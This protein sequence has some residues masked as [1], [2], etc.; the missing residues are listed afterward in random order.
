VRQL[1][2][3]QF[4]L[5]FRERQQLRDFFNIVGD[6]EYFGNVVHQ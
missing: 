3:Q 4:E 2:L 1:E 5:G 6:A